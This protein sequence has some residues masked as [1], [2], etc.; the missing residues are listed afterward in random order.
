MSGRAWRAT[1]VALVLYALIA[2]AVY[3]VVIGLASSH[4]APPP[5]VSRDAGDECRSGL[6]PGDPSWWPIC[7]TTSNP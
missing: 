4:R 6:D 7:N 3:A 2:V 5:S 1:L